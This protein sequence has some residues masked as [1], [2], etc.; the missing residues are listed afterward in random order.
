MS[1]SSLSFFSPEGSRT[2][3]KPSENE[4]VVPIQEYIL[5]LLLLLLFN[6][7]NATMYVM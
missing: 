3:R 5:L 2:N 1:L 6:A 7:Q 4:N